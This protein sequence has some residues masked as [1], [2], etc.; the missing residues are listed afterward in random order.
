MADTPAIHAEG[1]FHVYTGAEGNTVALRGLDLDVTAGEI[2]TIAGPSGSGKTTLLNCLAGFQRPTAGRLQAF[3][4]QLDDA[5]PRALA[6]YRAETVGIVRQHYFRAL[7]ADL[8]VR[9]LVALKTALLGWPAARRRARAL[10]LLE[11][12][13]LADRAHARRRELSGGEQQRVAVCAALAAAP[14]L[15]LADEPTGEL[16]DVTARDLLELIRALAHHHGATA[17]LVSHDPAV[18]QLSDRVIGIRDGRVVTVRETTGEELTVVD[19]AGQLRLAPETRQRASI[20]DRVRVHADDGHVRV[21]SAGPSVTHGSPSES[22]RARAR[23]RPEPLSGRP[24]VS[25]DQ[26]GRGYPSPAGAITA[27]ADVTVAF[28][29]G[30]FHVVAGPSGSGKTTLLHLVAGLERPTSGRVTTLERDLAALSR[31]E[32]ADLRRH[33]VAIV[34]QH[35]ALVPF[36]T[37]LEN[38]ELVGRIRGL[39]IDAARSRA[40]SALAEVALEDRARQRADELSGGERQRLAIARALAGQPALLLIDEPTANL[41]QANATILAELLDAAARR[42]G[43]T[44]ICATHDPVLISAAHRH[45]HLRSGRLDPAPQHHPA[46]A[47]PSQ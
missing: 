29:E 16:D 21:E 22:T 10:E 23:P 4:V 7:S 25:L 38:V 3:G 11:A 47:R 27:L 36:L 33:H 30:L 14:N 12:V 2:V 9:E 18:A 39:S 44:V 17:V 35:P 15:L 26:A 20:A 37:T 43:I 24:A 46:T 42:H 34:P 31:A 45:V 8:R 32:L 41:D 5:P 19:P 40:T 1:L 6:R 28:H 13:G